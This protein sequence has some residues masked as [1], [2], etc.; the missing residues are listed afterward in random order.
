LSNKNERVTVLPKI[1]HHHI[2]TVLASG[3]PLSSAKPVLYNNIPR[4]PYLT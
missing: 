2:N 1:L 3:A 4:K